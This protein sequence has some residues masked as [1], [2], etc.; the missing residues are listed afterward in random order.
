MERLS[1]ALL[2]KGQIKKIV[3]LARKIL[4]AIV[5]DALYRGMFFVYKGILRYL[6]LIRGIG[7]VVAG[8]KEEW[9]MTKEI[10]HVMPYTLVGRGGLRATYEIVVKVCEEDIPGDIVE[11]GVARGGCAALMA[12]V[13]FS[14]SHKGSQDRKMWLFDSY[15]GLPEPTEKD[16]GAGVS[17]GTGEHV[18]PLH[19][20]SC[21]GTLQE[22]RRL[23]FEV[24]CFPE[25]RI[26]F[27]KGWFEHTI[28]VTVGEIEQIA[29]LRIDGDWYES[30]KCCLEGLYEHVVDSGFIIID[31][32]QSCYGCKRAVDEFI[33]DK[34]LHPDIK[35]DGRGGCYFAKV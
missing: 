13:M 30:T 19:K 29:V 12:R 6:G 35:L 27:V 18:S 2:I 5:F 26:R 20:G 9:A 1:M 33:Q 11:A 32:Y 17:S 31:D 15:E 28:P 10:F 8:K 16:F 22:V 14:E 23:M 21:L 24:N 7:Y 4:P 25:S 3:Q 34:G